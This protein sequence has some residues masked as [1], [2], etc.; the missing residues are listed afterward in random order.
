MKVG[1]IGGGIVGCLT[2]H[3]LARRG[4]QVTLFEA[5]PSLGS[6]SSRS[7][8]SLL[9]FD[10]TISI[11]DMVPEKESVRVAITTFP[12]WSILHLSRYPFSST[13]RHDLQNI[14][15]EAED[16]FFDIVADFPS[17]P[18]SGPFVFQGHPSTRIAHSKDLIDLIS[19]NPSFDIF[20]DEKVIGWERND[21]GDRLDA[22]WTS[23]KRFEAD[24]FVLCSGH[25]PATILPLPI[26]PF[27]ASCIVD[28]NF[29]EENSPS[30]FRGVHKIAS[31]SILR[32]SRYKAQRDLG[33]QD[34]GVVEALPLTPDGLPLI[35][36]SPTYS[37][38]FF[39]V[40]HGF[41]G[42]TL[43]FWSS[44][45][46]SQM[47]LDGYKGDARVK[48]NRFIWLYSRG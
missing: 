20:L 40:G 46:I 3:T 47:V 13:I 17:F 1:V 36:G 33:A 42:W 48:L 18:Y 41:F 35:D 4:A 15:R 7:N 12:L 16:A 25:F 21:A 38:L 28:Y 29:Q 43:S 34:D 14:G 10:S 5:L 22:V 26:A 19:R 23:E 6:L 30:L 37:N 2:A 27:Y 32:D 39:N 9:A 44:R 45:V 24:A 31:G 11:Y 8:A